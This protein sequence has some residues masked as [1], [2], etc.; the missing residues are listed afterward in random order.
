MQSTQ[1]PEADRPAGVTPAIRPAAPWRVEV[2]EALP[3]FRL[4]VRFVDGTA[5]LVLMETFLRSPST[6][7]TVFE[8]LRDASRFAQAMCLDGAVTWPGGLDLA[9]DA[10]YDA[11][12]TRGEWTLE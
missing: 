3:D 2:V 12:R 9:P 5:G 8:P 6:T 11:I 7:G 1:T 10:M 4:R